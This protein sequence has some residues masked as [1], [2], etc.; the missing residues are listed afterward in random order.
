MDTEVPRE[1]LGAPLS[2]DLT[3]TGEAYINQLS[4]LKIKSK[5]LN[6]NI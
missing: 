2:C 3:S 4:N 6:K 5:L 1:L